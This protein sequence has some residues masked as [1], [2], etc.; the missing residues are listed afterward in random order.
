MTCPNC[1][2]HAALADVTGAGVTLHCQDCDARL[3]GATG[4]VV[5]AGSDET[6]PQ[7]EPA[8]S[9]PAGQDGMT[10]SPNA[11]RGIGTLHGVAT[12]RTPAESVEPTATA[13]GSLRLRPQN[14]AAPRFLA[15]PATASLRRRRWLPAAVIVALLLVLGIQSLLA[16]RARLAG[17]ARW[18]PLLQA[19]C[20]IAGCRLPAW[21]QPLAFTVLTRDVRAHPRIAGALTANATF[22]NDARW[23]QA[24]PELRLTLADA[25]GRTVGA[26][27]FA[28]AEYMGAV[29]RGT[30]APGQIAHISIDLHEPAP[31]VV[32][33]AFEFR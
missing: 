30:L 3:Q 20:G 5:T 17:D 25:D 11:A 26:R 1:G 15:G 2:S 12:M 21:R 7:D 13:D 8:T 16:D 10:D 33:F 28:P 27:V 6:P 29:P 22:R 24:W 18:R 4:D 32:A 19:V 14:A 31:A 9:V 23:A